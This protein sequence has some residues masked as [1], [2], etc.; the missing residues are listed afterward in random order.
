MLKITVLETPETVT[1][2]L[3]GRLGGPWVTELDRTW[4]V[5]ASSLDSKGVCIDLCDMTWAD[6]D[7]KH[8]LREIYEKSRAAFVSNTPLSR[9]FAAEAMGVGEKER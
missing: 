8:L 7:G 2:K 5:L 9:Y 3:E 6:A 4:R 1:I